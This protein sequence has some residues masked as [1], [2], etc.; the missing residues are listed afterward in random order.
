MHNIGQLTADTTLPKITF[1]QAVPMMRC[2]RNAPLKI[3]A[4]AVLRELIDGAR[5]YGDDLL[6][7]WTGEE[8]L[9]TYVGATLTPIK[10]ALNELERAGFII[11][12]WRLKDKSVHTRRARN[13]DGTWAARC[14]FVVPAA[15]DAIRDGKGSTA[16]QQRDRSRNPSTANR[17]RNPVSTLA[18]ISDLPQAESDEYRSRNQAT[19]VPNETV[20]N[21]SVITVTDAGTRED[22]DKQRNQEPQPSSES[23]SPEPASSSERSDDLSRA[24]RSQVGAEPKPPPPPP[25]RFVEGPCAHS[26][27]EPAPGCIEV[28]FCKDCGKPVDV[29]GTPLTFREVH[30]RRDPA[31]LVTVS[32]SHGDCETQWQIRPADARDAMLCETHVA[33][34]KRDEARA[35]QREL[36]ASAA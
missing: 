23:S 3:T 31:N 35:R 4:R 15:L 8:T 27:A 10:S 14:Y 5:W 18:G 34:A 11:R 13:F 19:T 16:N 9:G 24:S 17:S 21:E 6:V 20:T 1:E 25:K 28:W 2:V 22:N 33:L 29:N 32:C 7:N 12:A 30:E 26:N 36:R